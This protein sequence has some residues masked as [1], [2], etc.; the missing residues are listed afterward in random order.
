[1]VTLLGGGLE[2][3]GV[4]GFNFYVLC[5]KIKIPKRPVVFLGSFGFLVSAFCF[6]FGALLHRAEVEVLDEDILGIL[7]GL[8]LLI[9]GGQEAERAITR[10]LLALGI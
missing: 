8:R 7:D 5:K 9:E 3:V 6:C 1:M 2:I 10:R 4:L